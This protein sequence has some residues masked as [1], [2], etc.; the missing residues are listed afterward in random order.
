MY[1]P[2]YIF[3]NKTYKF[4]SFYENEDIVNLTILVYFKTEIYL[5]L[6][7]FLS[8]ASHLAQA[9]LA[10]LVRGR[11]YA[12]MNNAENSGNYDYFIE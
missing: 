9:E 5:L 6:A 3:Y 10:T 7:T 12:L 8:D 11:L 4:T 1:R 2:T